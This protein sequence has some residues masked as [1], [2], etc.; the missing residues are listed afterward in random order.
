MLTDSSL[1]YYRDSTAEEVRHQ[2]LGA[3]GRGLGGLVGSLEEYMDHRLPAVG[4]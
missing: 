3:P 1:K 4:R 2:V